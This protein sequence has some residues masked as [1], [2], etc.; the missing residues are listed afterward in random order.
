MSSGSLTPF[1][2]RLL[3]VLNGFEPPWTLTGGGALVGV[4][5]KH[6]VTRDLDLFWHGLDQL[7]SLPAEV[8]RRLAGQDLD[9]SQIQTAPAFARFRVSD[10]VEVCLIDLVADSVATVD[11]PLRVQVGGV[12]ISVDSP[13]EILVNKLCALLGRSEL[14]DLEDV[15]VLLESGESLERALV[16]APQK[17][18]GFSPLTLAWTLRGLQ[19]VVMARAA[20]WTEEK[21]ADLGKFKDELIQRLLAASDPDTGT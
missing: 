11:P 1:Q 20:G 3:E 7:G 2:W 5:L 15:Q 6:R 12:S 17:D 19:P 8:R 4:H 14:R 9:V 18:G 10:G 13:Y 16:D 21:A